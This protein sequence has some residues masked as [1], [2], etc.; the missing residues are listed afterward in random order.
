MQRN[1]F[2]HSRKEAMGISITHV[3][4]LEDDTAC[5]DKPPQESKQKKTE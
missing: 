5:Y 2:V 3:E 4:R 1:E